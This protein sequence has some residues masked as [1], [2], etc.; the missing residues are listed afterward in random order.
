MNAA[1]AILLV[2]VVGLPVLLGAGAAMLRRPWWWAAAVAVLLAFVA[3]VAPTPEEGESRL[4]VGDLGFVAV[5]AVVVTLL[6]WLG[7]LVGRRLA[8]GRPA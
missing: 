1:E 2:V 3:M 7:N 8:S 5:V 6:V 4:A